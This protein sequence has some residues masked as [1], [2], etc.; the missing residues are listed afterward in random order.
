MMLK[1]VLKFLGGRFVQMGEGVDLI[2]KEL[3]I[4]ERAKILDIGTGGGKMAILLA[5]NGYSVL[6]G[7]PEDDETKWAKR[8][9]EK[10][11]EQ[12]GVRD[13]IAFQHFNAEDMPFE[14]GEFDA[15]FTFG[16]FHHISRKRK[17][18]QECIRVVKK[19]GY[20]CI[21]E[22]QPHIIQSIKDEH[23]T[24][25]NWADPRDFLTDLPV[26]MEHKQKKNIDTYILKI[27][28]D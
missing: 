3:N 13:Q 4:P 9:W 18:L 20:I 6:T 16:S 5:L 17:M 24:H 26:I 8:D 7:E 21:V 23:P 25:P 11:A 15:I 12:I 10:N 1:E 22:P 28:K 14:V 27:Q 2:I 19:K